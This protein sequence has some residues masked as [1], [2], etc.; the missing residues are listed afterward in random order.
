MPSSEQNFQVVIP[1]KNWVL[2]LAELVSFLEARSVKFKTEVVSAAFYVI[3]LQDAYAV[4]IASLG[5]TIKIGAVT[6]NFTTQTVK[7]AFLEKSKQAQAQIKTAIASRSLIDG[8]FQKPSS[9][10]AVFG[11]SVYWADP[12]MRQASKIIQRFVGSAVKKELAAQGKKANFMG[13]AK[14]RDRPQLSHVEVLKKSMVENRAEVLFC[15]GKEQT[16]I[17]STVAV[18][19]PFEFQKRD[20]GKP[21][22][23]R[24]FAM[25]PRLARIMVNLAVLHAGKGS[26]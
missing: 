5:G 16:W 12:A 25:P 15:V 9:G 6:A 26:A 21:N 23:R 18:H 22:Q 3:N 24:I 19:N 11:V 2:S 20:V 4:D 14:N 8:M 10:K 13:F 1:G 7:E 17:A